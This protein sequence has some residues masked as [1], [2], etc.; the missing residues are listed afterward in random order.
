METNRNN[1]SVYV[2]FMKG[3]EVKTIEVCGLSHA[4]EYITDVIL[5]NGWKFISM[6]RGTEYREKEVLTGVQQK[7]LNVLRKDAEF[8]LEQGQFT[9]EASHFG[10]L[11]FKVVLNT[12]HELEAKK[13]ITLFPERTCYFDG[14][15]NNF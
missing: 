2:T 12:L 9:I 5:K 6:T 7:V 8:Y 11:S 3:V 1:C 15:I 4:A 10:G 14:K 13:L